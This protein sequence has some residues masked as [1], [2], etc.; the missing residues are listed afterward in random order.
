MRKIVSIAPA[1]VVLLVAIVTLAAAPTA[2]RSMQT[3]QTQTRV[4]LA[5]QRLGEN[6][7]LER[8][9][10]AVADLAEVVEP[11]VVHIDAFSRGRRGGAMSSGSGW[12]FDDAGHIITNA[13]VIR[14]AD[15]YTVQFSD[16]YTVRAEFVGL[17]TPTDVGVLKVEDDAGAI[18]LKRAT[19]ERLR[20]GQ[21]VYAFGSP[22]G[23]RFSM[24]EGIVSALGRNA[25]GVTGLNGYTNFIQTDAAVNPGN[26][27]GPLV[28]V[29]G[30]VVGMNTAIVTADNQDASTGQQGQSAGI[31]FAI[32]LDTIE[33][34]AGQII[35]SGIVV[36]GYLGISLTETGDPRLRIGAIPQ[37]FRG[38][39]VVVLNVVE[40]Q[41]AARAGLRSGDIIIA[42][43]GERTP[44]SAVLRAKVGSTRPGSTVTMRVVR[45]TD[46]G[47]EEL[48]I[49]V[50]IGAAVVAANNNL[51]AVPEEQ[52]PAEILAR[53]NADV[54]RVNE[55][56]GALSRL[57]MPNLNI[58]RGGITLDVRP[59]S[60]AANAGMSSSDFVIRV[61]GREV[62]GYES[63]TDAVA[64][65]IEARPPSPLE[66]VLRNSEGEERTVTIPLERR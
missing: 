40:G 4:A 44:D 41:P 56:L 31:G 58:R 1:L 18:P 28:D 49:P 13:H 48:D 26:S 62:E 16:G 19:G 10:N 22:F 29:V 65:A 64:D 61:N 27:G 60:V 20:Q 12:V 21:R 53:E 6:D 32:P 50:E 2:I 3:A 43:N 38:S 46:D 57:G 15:F 33:S 14:G 5:Q 45:A 7:V 17:D 37:G 52:D 8:L 11:S 59:D 9:S 39:G 47:F 30:R 36:K 54:E 66:L 51:I 63:F 23:F 42:V 35:E 34:V 24:S 55:A 25:M